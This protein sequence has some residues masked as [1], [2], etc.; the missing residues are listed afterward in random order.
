MKT[1]LCG[2]YAPTLLLFATLTALGQFLANAVH[3]A[4]AAKARMNLLR[5]QFLFR[6]S[7]DLD[8]KCISSHP[9][10]ML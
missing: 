6:A 2:R 9:C 5:K 8:A 4:N 1:A 10:G 3:E 7:L